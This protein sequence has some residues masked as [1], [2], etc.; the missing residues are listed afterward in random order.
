WQRQYGGLPN[1][2]GKKIRLDG[3]EYEVIGV[4][5]QGFIFPNRVVEVWR[6]LLGSIP[7]ELQ[8]RHDLHNLSVVARLRQGV[9]LEQGR[10]EVDGMSAGYKHGDPDES[11]GKGANAVALHGQLVRDV[12]TPLIVL[13]GAVG[14]VLLIACVNIASLLLTRAALRTREIGIRAALGAGRG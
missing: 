6:P 12:R 4:M 5:P 14:C 1:A 3:D 10:A 7:R 13:L 2:V 11:T 8:A 9:S